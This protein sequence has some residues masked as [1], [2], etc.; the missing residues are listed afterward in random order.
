VIAVNFGGAYGPAKLWPVEHCGALA[1]MIAEQS[2][3]DVLV[4]CGPNERD[5]AKAIVAAANCARVFSLAHQPISLALSKA[6]LSRCRLLVS[7]DSGPRHIAAAL[8]LP[9]VTLMG[10]TLPVWIENPTVR[11]IFVQNQIECLGCGQRACPL[12]HHR[13]MRDIGPERV[14]AAVN[15]LLEQTFERAA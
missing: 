3:H 6:C 8:G 2:G 4:L 12:K 5:A 14:F 11:G 7:T 1:C 9:V 13:C 10:P 15:E